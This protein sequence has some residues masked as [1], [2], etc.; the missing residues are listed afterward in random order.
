MPKFII[1]AS[2]D[3]FFLPDSSQFYFDELRGDKYLCYVPNADHS[4]DDSDAAQS[5]LAFYLTILH[6]RPRPSAD[7][8]FDPD[9]TVQ[10]TPGSEPREVALWQA[11][12]SAARDFR[13]ETLGKKYEKTILNRQD[14]GSLRMREFH[15]KGQ[16]GKTPTKNLSSLFLRIFCG[17]VFLFLISPTLIVIPISFSS[18]RFL[19][20]PPPG[21]SLQWY[22]NYFGGRDW[23]SATV[24]SFEVA[25]IT[26]IT[27]TILGTLL[28]VTLVRGKFPCKNIIYFMAVSP[29]I[30]PLIITAISLYFFFSKL[31]L[32][33]TIPGLVAA[34]TVLT[35]PFVLVIV[36]GTLKGFDETL[37]RASLSLGA[38]PLKTFLYVTF[39]IIRP[40]VISGALFAFIISFDELVV[41]IFISG[42]SGVTLP[43]RM[44]DGIRLEI[45]PTIAAVSSLLVGLS[46]MM[47]L[48]M[49]VIKRNE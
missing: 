19:K 37:E 18:S 26:T 34:H 20:F 40:G 29:M 13:V 8:K 14:D 23:I 22:E 21:F 12:N 9:G 11:T 24:L 2:G 44:W 25:A 6:D 35:I 4:L 45:D 5:L 32:V 48:L 47:L 3:Q 7:W 17:F 15:L 1:N 36:S 30:V 38:N 33:G 16:V 39:P 27:A 42:V 49:N 43:K 46:S 28:A 31:H 10:V 41:V